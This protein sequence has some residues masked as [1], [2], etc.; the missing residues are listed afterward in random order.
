MRRAG[1]PWLTIAKVTGHQ[2]I[3]N[4]IKNYDLGLEVRNYKKL[5]K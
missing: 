2:S 4:L 5:I 3:E 1:V